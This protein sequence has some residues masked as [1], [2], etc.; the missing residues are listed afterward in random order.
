M[1]LFSFKCAKYF[2]FSPKYWLLLGIVLNLILIPVDAEDFIPNDIP[3]S[4]TNGF[5]K[6]ME[7]D[8]Q[9]G[10][11]AWQDD[12]STI[13]WVADV[14]PNT[15]VF[16]PS[17]GMG[18]LVDQGLLP[19][20][21]TKNG[22]EWVWGLPEAQIVYS[23][24]T[25][26]QPLKSVV[27]RAYLNGQGTW[28][29]GTLPSTNSFYSPTGSKN[30]TDTNGQVI[31]R[32]DLNSK[33]LV[34]NNFN[35]SGTTIRPTYLKSLINPLPISPADSAR[36]VIG[37]ITNGIVYSVLV[38]GYQQIFYLD[39]NTGLPTQ[40]TFDA[41]NKAST[42]MWSAPEYNGDLLLM[43]IVDD[44]KIQIWRSSSTTKNPTQ[45]SFDPL[46]TIQP[47]NTR[48]YMDSPEP[49]VYKGQSYIFYLRADNISSGA[50]GYADLFFSNV[51]PDSSSNPTLTRQV[52]SSVPAVRSDPEYY[53]YN[54]KN[55]LN[56]DG[57]FP[58][59]LYYTEIVQSSKIIHRCTTGL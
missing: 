54:P 43:A 34:L 24:Q 48:P 44:T 52:S 39:I 37:A 1:S 40:L 15:G 57:E 51:T 4:D 53:T 17:N 16:I 46:T 18:V 59:F 13:L 22:P 23:K 29:T 12:R 8:I 9:G 49:F 5:M 21:I 38:N 28:V 3:A 25:S 31:S 20:S 47:P 32:N 41:T 50:K 45:G 19:A 55:L 30:S 42:F 36:W 56:P 7:F 58:V 14:D 33:L 10:H 26:A 2:F 11:L 35:I 27:N 6:D